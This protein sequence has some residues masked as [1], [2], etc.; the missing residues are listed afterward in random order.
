MHKPPMSHDPNKILSETEI[1]RQLPL[2][3]ACVCL[4]MYLLYM[5]VLFIS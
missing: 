3:I 2:I 4:G 1:L 5:H